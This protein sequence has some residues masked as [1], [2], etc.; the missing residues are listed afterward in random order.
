MESA[1]SSTAWRIAHYWASGRDRS[2]IVIRGFAR[3]VQDHLGHGADPEH[4]QRLAGWVSITHTD[5][6]DLD[7]A[8]RYAD[9]PQPPVQARAGHPC[10]CRGGPA[11]RGGAP[12]PAI[13]RQL[14]RRPPD[15]RA[16]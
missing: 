5:C 3:Q 13:L 7:L 10:P 9:A 2:Q 1:P 16:A 11:R 6:L 15:Q 12:A 4:L 14:I 8:M